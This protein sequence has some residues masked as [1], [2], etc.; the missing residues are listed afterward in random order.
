MADELSNGAIVAQK[1][2][3]VTKAESDRH[4]KVFVVLS[5]GAKPTEDNG[6]AHEANKAA[7][8]QYMISQGLRPTG[9]VKL[10]SIKEHPTG[11]GD[12]WDVTYSVPAVPAERYEGDPVRVIEGDD[13]VAHATKPAAD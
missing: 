6:Y 11:K 9:D 12:V 2:A 13:N 8:R 3:D 5:P 7:V 1:S 10:D 4:V